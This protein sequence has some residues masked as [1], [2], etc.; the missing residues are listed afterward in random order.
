MCDYT[1]NYEISDED[2][3]IMMNWNWN[4]H[5]DEDGEWMYDGGF[6]MADEI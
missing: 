5:E 2:Y 6:D 3:E 4:D 1:T